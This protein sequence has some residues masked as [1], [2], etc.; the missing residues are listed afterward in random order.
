MAGDGI[1]VDLDDLR[2]VTERLGRFITEFDELGDATDDVQDA[3]G[4]PTGDG[5][6]RDR[7]GD[8]ESGWNGNREVVQESLDNVHSHLVDFIDNIEELDR[9]LATEEE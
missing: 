3:V 7:V 1:D 9:N 4:R 2:R 6:L 5:R 8:F